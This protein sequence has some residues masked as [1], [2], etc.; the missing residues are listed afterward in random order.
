MP[1]P[2]VL[3]DRLVLTAGC[4]I[5]AIWALAVVVLVDAGAIAWAVPALAVI[6]TGTTSLLI[7]TRARNNAERTQL[8]LRAAAADARARM[9]ERARG[10][11]LGVMSVEFRT[12]LNAIMIFAELLSKGFVDGSPRKRSEYAASI[13]ATGQ[14]LIEKLDALLDQARLEAGELELQTEEVDPKRLLEIVARLVEGDARS[15]A[16]TLE[17]PTA[18]AP[19]TL[20]A[21]SRRLKHVFATLFAN[22]VR[23]TRR[24]GCVSVEIRTT[25]DG[26]G[27]IVFA[28]TGSGMTEQELEQALEPI[29]AREGVVSTL[30]ETSWRGLWLAKSLTE[31]HGGTFTVRSAPTAGTTVT[32]GFPSER[33]A[34]VPAA[35]MTDAAA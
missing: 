14:Q 29:A 13:F 9:A 25:R 23:L 8:D 26:G 30:R 7:A 6:A 21:D 18:P 35:T 22:A 34:V 20:L 33:C 31:L 12:P 5:L 27:E 11:A 10:R 32:I 16:V 17:M 24:E 15:S 4:T 1:L 3:T 19:F 2:S 28:H